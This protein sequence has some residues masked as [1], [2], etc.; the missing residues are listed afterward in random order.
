MATKE[1]TSGECVA[2]YGLFGVFSPYES[3]DGKVEW[4]VQNIDPTYEDEEP[5]DVVAGSIIAE[6]S[7]NSD[8]ELFAKAKQLK[9]IEEQKLSPRSWL[10]LTMEERRQIALEHPQPTP[11]YQAFKWR[12]LGGESWERVD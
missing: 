6:F 10:N 12:Y 1:K 11:G 9:V 3:H 8:A 5:V 7:D 4:T 2:I